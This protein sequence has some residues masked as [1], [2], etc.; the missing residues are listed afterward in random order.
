MAD[1]GWKFDKHISAGHLLSAAAMLVAVAAAFYGLDKRVAVNEQAII[2]NARNAEAIER[3][4][5]ERISER[6]AAANRRMDEVI[7]WLR[8][9]S[10]KV[11]RL[12]EQKADKTSING[13]PR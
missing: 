12:A 10:S 11:D 1:T 13:V 9:I 5:N 7:G 2:V 3:R 4:I 8:V 6:E